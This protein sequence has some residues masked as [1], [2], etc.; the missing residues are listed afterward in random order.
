MRSRTVATALASSSGAGG[1]EVRNC[2]VIRTHPMSSDTKPVGS[3]VPRTSSVDPPP[4][5]TT[6]KGAGASRSAV[7]PRNESAASSSPDSSSG[8]TPSASSAG[9]KKSSRLVASRAAL[10]AVARTRS[11]PYSSIA[12][13]YSRST[14]TVRC[15]RLGCERTGAIDALAEPGDAHPPVERVQLGVAARAVDVGDEQAGGIRPDV[16]RRD[17]GHR[18]CHRLL[19][20]TDVVET[21]QL[22]QVGG[23]R[24]G[25]RA[26]HS[27]TGSVPSTRN[28]A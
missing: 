1:S 12:A 24:R 18:A 5:S 16:D 9:S 7:A 2:S 3:S 4:M 8:V 27:P 28:A 14:S 15:N 19:A 17:P 11:A 13:R 10:V 6:R 26:T 23:D 25:W 22:T 20:S 21:P